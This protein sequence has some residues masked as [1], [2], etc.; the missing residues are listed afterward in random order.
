MAEL[1]MKAIGLFLATFVLGFIF[2][3]PTAGIAY[4]IC[5]HVNID[6]LSN[7][8]FWQVYGLYWLI[9]LV[10]PQSTTTVKKS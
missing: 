1:I 5:Q 8:S 4:F 6:F 9:R 7:L 3:F 10:I 2:S